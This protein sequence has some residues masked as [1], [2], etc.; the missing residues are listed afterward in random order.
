MSGTNNSNRP[1]R[2]CAVCGW[3]KNDFTVDTAVQKK[4]VRAFEPTLNTNLDQMLDG[5]SNT[6]NAQQPYNR[7]VPMIVINPG[8]STLSV[9]ETD[10]R[11]ALAAA[12][13]FDNATAIALNATADDG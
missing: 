11:S 5:L 6:N 1:A 10:I 3:T 7:V 12:F 2:V 9:S 8:S 13:L 4:S